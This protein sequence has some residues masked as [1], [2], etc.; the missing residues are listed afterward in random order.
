MVTVETVLAA[1]LQ[2]AI[3]A[4]KDRGDR[5]LAVSPSAFKRVGLRV[6]AFEVTSYVLAYQS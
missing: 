2:Q 5:I 1:D 4:A 6:T 3:S